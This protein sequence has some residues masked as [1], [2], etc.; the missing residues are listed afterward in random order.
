[1]GL[2]ALT[3]GLACV[4]MFWLNSATRPRSDAALISL[5]LLASWGCYT[6]LS[7]INPWP[8]NLRLFALVDL[9]VGLTCWLCWRTERA[10]WKWALVWLIVAQMVW[11]GVFW[12]AIAWGDQSRLTGTMW[13]YAFG[14]NMLGFLQIA[15]G[16]W[17]GVSDVA[18]RLRAWLSGG[19][20]GGHTLGSAR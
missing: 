12:T 6:F 10:W 1:M 18:G 19:S 16:A 14:L 17:P 4:G 9:V 3:S 20:A 7:A 5:A 13:R 11:H 2:I 8:E 15:L